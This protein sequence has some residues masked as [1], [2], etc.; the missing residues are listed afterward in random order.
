MRALGVAAIALGVSAAASRAEA[1]GHLPVAPVAR[2]VPRAQ[3]LHGDQRVDDYAWLERRNDPAVLGYLRAEERF[4]ER[5]MA[6][7]RP[8][9][10]RLYREI[11]GRLQES[12]RTL[13]YREGA[14]LYYRRTEKG[15]QYPIYCRTRA[16][17][18]ERGPEQVL[19]DV[20]RLARHERFMHLGDFEVSDDGARLAYITDVTGGRDYVLRGKDVDGNGERAWPETRAHVSSLAWAADGRTLFYITDDAA[21]RPHRLWRHAVGATGPDALVYEE[22]DERFHLWIERTRSR[23]WLVLGASSLTATEVRVLR[24][25]APT[26]AFRLIAPR[27]KDHEYFVD[28]R[29][30]LFYIRTNRGAPN[31]RI[32]TAPV[33]DPRPHN[34]RELVPHRPDVMIEDHDVFAHHLLLSEREDG[35]AQLAVH[36]L[37]DGTHH[38][39]PFPEAVYEARVDENREFDSRVLRYAYES[40]T[41]PRSIYDY[42][43]DRRAATLKKRVP[44]LGGYDPTRYATDRLH[45]RAA[46]GT[47]VPISIVY[48]KD[49]ARDGGPLLLEGYGAYGVPDTPEFDPALPSLLDRGVA[50]ALA[51]VR[52][53]GELGKR[54]HES[55]RMLQKRNTFTDFIACA[56]HLVAERW[57]APDRLIIEGSSAGG[58]LIGVVVNER[59][60]L[61]HAAIARM[62]FVDVI[63]TMLNPALPLTV[64]EFEEWGNP[65]R[66]AEYAYLRSYSPYDNVGA[67]AYPTMLVETALNDSQVMYWEPA[68]WVARLRARK[69]D[70]RPL[71]LKV[72]LAPAGHGGPSGRYEQIRE[73]AFDYA[74]IL[75]QLGLGH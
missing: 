54:W 64:G 46:D 6:P 52:G 10:D 58:L 59:P 18:G 40:F 49:R 68:K 7:L 38:R 29:G 42:D 44:V 5:A 4:T 35:L 23:A 41:T 67:H 21:Q 53:G 65:Q 28:H 2:R 66:P 56:E 31:F 11:V 9:E 27:E 57:T 19:L 30:D 22:S 20:N 3:L 47:T 63:N 14:Y 55:G 36:N 73:T 72:D 70:D 74:F 51:H 39:I 43:F 33:D 1:P 26:G 15:K 62:P 37:D 16:A 75:G 61:F 8:L 50:F 45:A 12:D 71:L 34:W 13:P 17:D 60:E 48:R 69:T 24:A 25:D 32:V